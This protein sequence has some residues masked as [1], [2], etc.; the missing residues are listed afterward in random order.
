MKKFKAVMVAFVLAGMTVV[1]CSSDDSS[2]TPAAIEGKWNQVRTVVKFGGQTLSQPYEEDTEGCEKNYIE[3]VAGGVFNDVVYFRQGGECVE[4]VADAGSW[5]KVDD[6]LTINDGGF[7]SGN[8]DY[9]LCT[10]Y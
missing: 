4:S 6:E 1:S 5:V 10:E 9:C 8:Y 3:F 7:L 2:G